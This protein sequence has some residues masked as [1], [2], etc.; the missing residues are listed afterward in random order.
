MAG[1]TQLPPSNSGSRLKAN[2]IILKSN[3]AASLASEPT[4]VQQ[5]SKE[6]SQCLIPH[7]SAK[8]KIRRTWWQLLLCILSLA[9]LSVIVLFVQSSKFAQRYS[10]NERRLTGILKIDASTSLFI[11]RTAQAVLSTITSACLGDA[12]EMI[13]LT[14]MNT[15]RGIPF[16]DLLAL[17][18]ATGQFTMLRLF[19]SD[20]AGTSARL[21]T[22]LRYWINNFSLSPRVDSIYTCM[23]CS[24]CSTFILFRGT[25]TLLIWLSGIPILVL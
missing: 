21:W 12:M 18:S 17:S 1:P 23:T 9:L 20:A 11:L 7:Q 4:P 22:S 6:S 24:R 5:H 25:L 19:F 10:E 14:I 15:P 2:T 16:S 3:S 8:S 13:Q